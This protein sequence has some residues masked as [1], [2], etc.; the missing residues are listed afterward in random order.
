VI[1]V[2]FFVG[3]PVD[4]YRVV[5]DF[6]Y[7]CTNIFPL[8]RSGAFAYDMCSNRKGAKNAAVSE[9]PKVCAT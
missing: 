5:P 3:I 9:N 8:C 2:S 1:P 4:K 7:G 6:A